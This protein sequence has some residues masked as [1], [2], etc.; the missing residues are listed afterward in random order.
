MENN[1][2]FPNVGIVFVSAFMCASLDQTH[3]NNPKMEQACD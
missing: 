3:A 1:I 2:T